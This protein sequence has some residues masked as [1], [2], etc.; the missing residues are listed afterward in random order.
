MDTI[1]DSNVQIIIGELD[2]NVI[3]NIDIGNVIGNINVSNLIGNVDIANVIGNVDIGN[4]DIG[5]VNI[6]IDIPLGNS[7]VKVDIKHFDLNK[8][9]STFVVSNDYTKIISYPLS[10]NVL[11]LIKILVKDSPKSL[12]KMSNTIKDIISDGKLDMSD[13]P[14]IVLLIT[15]LNNTNLKDVFKTQNIQKSD[16]FD[17]IKFIIHLIVELK[18]VKVEDEKKIFEMLDMSLTLL[19]TNLDISSLVSMKPSWCCHQ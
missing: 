10:D 8:T 7:E 14:K 1:N 6:L 16:L 9:L 13:I 18:Y 3:A 15:E 4:V 11:N 17:L 19:N 12:E 2:S 5:N